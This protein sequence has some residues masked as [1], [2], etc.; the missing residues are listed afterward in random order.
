MFAHHPLRLA[1]PSLALPG[2]ALLIALA[3]SPAPAQE[4]EEVTWKTIFTGTTDVNVVNVDVVVTDKKGRPVTGLGAGD[5]ELFENGK[6]VEISNFYA[7]AGAPALPG[8]EAPID[9]AEATIPQR[10]HHMILFVDQANIA[11]INRARILAR[12]REFLLESWRDDLR[13]MVVSNTRTLAVHSDGFATAP[14][15]VF[16]A[17][18]SIQTTTSVGQRFDVERRQLLNDIGDLNVEA[19]SGFFATTSGGGQTQ[20]QEQICLEVSGAARALLPRI[21]AL[22]EQQMV[23][24]RQSLG[25]I[26]EFISMAAGLSGRKSV[27]YISDGVPVRPARPLFD[28]LSRRV[29]PIANEI[30]IRPD[31]ET[32]RY[33]LSLDFEDLVTRANT[34]GVA[35]YTLYSDTS[36]AMERGSAATA[37]GAGGNFGN[38]SS[39]VA[40]GIERTLQ[41][42]LI[43]M[44]EETGGRYA[45]GAENADAVLDGLIEDGDNYYSLGYVAKPLEED[46]ARDVR[47][48]VSNNNWLLRF[49]RRFGDLTVVQRT[50]EH[51]RAALLADPESN[52][53]GISVEALEQSPAEEETF[54]VPLRI[55]VPLE[56]LVLLPGAAQHQAQVSIFVMVR[57]ERGRVSQI[58][59][60]LCPIR[61]AND[62]ML[63]A[64]GRSAACGVNLRMRGGSQRVAVSLLDEVA[65]LDS[66]RALELEVGA[67]AAVPEPAT[68]TAGG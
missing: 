60:H 12:L 2:L 10:L 67:E 57:D 44:A 41:E 61:I 26:R 7:A 25:I 63:A 34:G 62:E 4:D 14:H 15:D 9:E 56:R 40:N 49:R 23:H 1:L 19:C 51:T 31:L 8:P 52:P 36:A 27:V 47:V 48:T 35:F 42:S 50:E 30:E 6:R 5:F 32:Q 55:G 43:I 45:L 22:A 46:A 16:A 18:E 37:A 28:G 11:E 68:A 20:P 38:W 66:T 21:R 33:D 59:R 64:R 17:L 24:A 39:D 3:P 58:T 65:A 54:L 53:L 29:E 13:V